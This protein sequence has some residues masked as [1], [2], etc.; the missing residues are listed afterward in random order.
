LDTKEIGDAETKVEARRF[1]PVLFLALGAAILVLLAAYLIGWKKSAPKTP[2]WGSAPEGTP[3]FYTH[4]TATAA[5]AEMGAFSN[6]TEDGGPIH[7]NAAHLWLGSVPGGD[8]DDGVALPPPPGVGN[9]QAASPSATLMPCSQNQLVVLVSTEGLTEA[10]K[11][12]TAYLN[13]FADWN[14]DGRFDGGDGC[15]SEW[16]LQNHELSLSTIS[17]GINAVAVSIPTG[18][19]TFE[20]WM[21]A[22]ITVDEPADG[23]KPRQ[24][25]AEGEIEDV[26]VT[27][28]PSRG[29]SH[30]GRAGCFGSLPPAIAGGTSATVPG[31]ISSDGLPDDSAVS[32]LDISV[33][34]DTATETIAQAL[35][36]PSSKMAMLSPSRVELPTYG[37]VA[38]G[39]ERCRFVTLPS[40]SENQGLPGSELDSERITLGIETP[41]KK[42]RLPVAHCSDTKAFSGGSAI[43]PVHQMPCPSVLRFCFQNEGGDNNRGRGALPHRLGQST[44]RSCCIRWFWSTGVFEALSILGLSPPIHRSQFPVL[45]LLFEHRPPFV[46]MG[47]RGLQP[48]TRA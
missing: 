2:D 25:F 19:Q 17:E 46:T 13:L 41:S 33:E 3:T 20:F 35:L 11:S 23:P 40:T 9:G 15:A 32:P 10:Q 1:W 38:I 8:F 27:T 31:R 48:A 26:L 42:S 24:P 29:S 34:F 30:P 18:E 14:R 6:R 45:A 28:P 7:R 12:Q 4:L 47:R 16:A 5:P 22:T 21:R 36:D 44:V 43:I 37:F 39:S